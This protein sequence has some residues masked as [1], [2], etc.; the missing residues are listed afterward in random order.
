MDFRSLLDDLRRHL[1]ASLS[2]ASPLLLAACGSTPSGQDEGG[3]TTDPSG[4]GSGVDD[5]DEGTS[6]TVPPN[7]SAST[8]PEP[9][10]DEEEES[11]ESESGESES[12]EPESESESEGDG[13]GDGDKL[14]LPAQPDLPAPRDCTV[15]SVPPSTLDEHPECEIV[16]Q[17][18]CWDLH[19]GCVD[20]EPGETCEQLCP[21]GDCVIDWWSCDG[22]PL[23]DMP[24]SVCGPYEVDGQCCSL[25]DSFNFCGTDGRP[26]VVAGLARQAELR[27]RG[28]CLDVDA[29]AQLPERVR[30][31]LTRHWTAIAKAEHA[32]IASFAQFAA[33]L[34]A[35][36][37]PPGLIRDA[38]AAA[39]DEVRHA[40]LA[41][42]R[43]SEL[44]GSPL[45]FG[46]LDTET[47]SAS[48]R[49]E[50]TVLACVREG[51]IGETLAALELG[52]A[53]LA[54]DD[55]ELAATLHAIAADEARHAALAWRFVAWALERDPG[56]ASAVAAVF[57]SLVIAAATPERFDARERQLLRMHGCLPAD[58]RRRVQVDGL[59]ELL[60]PCAAALLGPLDASPRATQ[61]MW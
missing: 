51:C 9:G 49:F 58:E 54:C 11:G 17:D 31:Q 52:A 33:R 23:Y 18:G 28:E 42:A 39:S 47:A 40:E 53:A 57:D 14:D 50:D 37:A 45:E 19:W 27:S 5:E 34:L 4:D 2:V 8:G 59:R 1:L 44:G 12:G 13:D 26:F 43:A 56:L 29:H 36:A 30:E 7:T 48:E 32:S 61:P 10:T 20:L 3:V 15:T 55:P 6:G 16:I 22:D 38:L 25:A 21:G 60:R 24:N 46:A 35:L 41:L